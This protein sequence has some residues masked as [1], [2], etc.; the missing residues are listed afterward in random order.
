MAAWCCGGCSKKPLRNG[1]PCTSCCG[2][3]IAHIELP[4]NK[5]GRPFRQPKRANEAVALVEARRAMGA[6]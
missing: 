1:R 6:A 5:Q 2:W 3:R 4:N